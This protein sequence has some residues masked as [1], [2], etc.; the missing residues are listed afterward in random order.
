MTNQPDAAAHIEKIQYQ[1]HKER[2]Q[3]CPLPPFLCCNP[4]SQCSVEKFPLHPGTMSSKPEPGV[5][6]DGEKFSSGVSPP[7][8]DAKDD[9]FTTPDAAPTAAPGDVEQ[10]EYATG[11]RLAAI[12]ITIFLGTLLAAIDIVSTPG[13][14]SFVC[15][16]SNLCLTRRVLLPR[17]SQASPTTSTVLT[18]S[19]GMEAPAS[20]SSEA[21]PQCGASCINTSPPSSSISPP[22]SSS[23]LEASWPRPRRTALR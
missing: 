15:P 11:F 14:L 1:Q 7:T 2:F 10:P 18:T 21:L 13:D 8:P 9:G 23:S 3:L 22:S 5:T 20:C 4:S 6:T 19:A 17:P 12:M 16:P